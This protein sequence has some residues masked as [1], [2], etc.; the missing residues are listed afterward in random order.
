MAGNFLVRRI[1]GNVN[2]LLTY[3][4][5]RNSNF[6]NDVLVNLRLYTVEVSG[7]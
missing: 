2:K 4:Y 5:A 7:C 6:T 1:N 3:S